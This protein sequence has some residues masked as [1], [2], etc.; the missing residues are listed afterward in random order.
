MSKL[1]LHQGEW[2]VIC[3]GAKALVLENVG[4]EMFPNL[5]TKE[6]YQHPDPLT[7]ELGTDEPGRSFQSVGTARSAMEQADWH[8]QEEERFLAKL[9]ARL[10]TAVRAG[11]T[12]SLVIAA[13]PRALGVLRRAYT[14][15]LRDAIRA[16]IDKDLVRMPLHDIE[17]H[18]A[19]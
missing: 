16:E 1:K 5:R 17:K 15:G 9:V 3:D 13:P 2:V 19:A 11:E 8:G 18:L 6:V 4:D 10:D 14:H 12:K 7:R